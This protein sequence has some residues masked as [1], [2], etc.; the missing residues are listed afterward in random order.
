MLR[1]RLICMSKYAAKNKELVYTLPNKPY[2]IQIPHM[3]HGI[4][5]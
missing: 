2:S 4:N 3:D 5:T 1:N